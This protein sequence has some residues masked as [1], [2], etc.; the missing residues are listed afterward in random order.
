MA[1]MPLSDVLLTE[2]LYFRARSKT[3]ARA[4]S[5]DLRVLLKGNFVHDDPKTTG[6]LTR[7]ATP[8]SIS[9]PVAF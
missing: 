4:A 3:K 1:R 9:F 6:V 8:R 7:N 5:N 2:G